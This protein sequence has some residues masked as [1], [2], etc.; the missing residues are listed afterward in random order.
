MNYVLLTRIVSAF[1]LFAAMSFHFVIT[2][3]HHIYI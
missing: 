1:S 3:W 2:N